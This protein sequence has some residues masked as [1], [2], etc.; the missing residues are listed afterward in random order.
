MTEQK[1]YR[2]LVYICSR[3]SGNKE[4]NLKATEDFCR[5]RD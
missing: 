5:F 3:F 4:E 1:S 2:P